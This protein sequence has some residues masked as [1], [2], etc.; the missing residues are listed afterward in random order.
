MP[1]FNNNIIAFNGAICILTSD[2]PPT[3][4]MRYIICRP[5]Q[6]SPI[7]WIGQPQNKMLSIWVKTKG[8]KIKKN[9]KLAL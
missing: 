7:I 1:H 3:T 9:K 6:K 4:G 2:I 5:L 8:K